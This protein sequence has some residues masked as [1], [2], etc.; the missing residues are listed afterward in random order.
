ML[1]ARVIF[2]LIEQS[3]YA[4]TFLN[5]GVELETYFRNVPY[6]EVATNIMANL[7]GLAIEI[8]PGLTTS[9]FLAQNGVVDG[10]LPEIVGQPD[11]GEG[12]HGCQ[13]LGQF[14]FEQGGDIPQDLLTKSG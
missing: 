4:E 11:V 1:L 6:P 5:G 9:L 14:S 10:R 12:H 7:P 2:D 8:N 13:I 3:L